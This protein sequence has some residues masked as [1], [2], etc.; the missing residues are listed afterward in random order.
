MVKC[1]RNYDNLATSYL[2]VEIARRT[3]AFTE[4]NPGVK[5][6]RLGIGNTTEPLPPI[7]SEAIQRAG[8][9]LGTIEGYGRFG[10]YGDEQGINDLR[11]AVAVEYDKRGIPLKPQEIFIGD[12]AKSDLGNIQG[13]FAPGIVA[14]QD[15]VYPAYL[16]VTAINGR[17]GRFNEDSGK[18][19]KVVYMPCIPENGFAPE[20]P[21]GKVD[22]IYLCS[23]NNPTCAVMKKRDLEK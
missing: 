5:V 17:S 6:M 20:L 8:R 14:L 9:E 16:D 22:L 4:K 23:P 13:I 18:Y 7:I 12:G 21:R 1:N 2:F 11:E 10:G 15:P 19:A 3:R